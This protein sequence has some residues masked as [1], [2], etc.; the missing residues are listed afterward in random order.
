MIFRSDF[1]IKTQFSRY[2]LASLGM[3][4]ALQP[5]TL[6]FKLWLQVLSHNNALGAK[7]VLDIYCAIVRDIELL[8]TDNR[9]FHREYG[10]NENTEQIQHYRQGH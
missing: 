8:N 3:K 9:Y 4:S 5:G 10:R 7:R 2:R 1:P 6:T